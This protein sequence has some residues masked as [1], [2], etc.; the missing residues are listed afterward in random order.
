MVNDA[1]ESVSV[2]KAL[3]EDIVNSKSMI[4]LG[5]LPRELGWLPKDN[6]RNEISQSSNAWRGSSMSE[7]TRMPFL[8]AHFVMTTRLQS[9]EPQ[10]G[11]YID[12]DWMRT[13]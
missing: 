6:S 7:Q 1:I 3:T 4:F 12:R 9:A 13:L 8:V 10:S 5:L 11:F 2:R